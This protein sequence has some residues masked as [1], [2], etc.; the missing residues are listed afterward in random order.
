[1]FRS[2]VG[3]NSPGTPSGGPEG[4]RMSPTKPEPAE[5]RDK[6]T[7]LDRSRGLWYGPGPNMDAAPGGQPI[8]GVTYGRLTASHPDRI[9]LDARVF[10]LRDGMTCGI[11]LGIQVKVV[12]IERDGRKYVE[13]ITRDR[14]AT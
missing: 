5:P 13:S 4:V 7:I 8:L 10:Y 1:M 12:Y 2:G 6:V 14:T 9:H 3:G 11:P